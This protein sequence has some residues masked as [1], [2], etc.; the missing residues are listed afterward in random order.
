VLLLAAPTANAEGPAVGGVRHLVLVTASDSPVDGLSSED[1]RDAY[2]AFPIK[3]GDLQI[4]PLLNASDPVVYEV[5]LQK[6]L[7]MSQRNY[8]RYVLSQVFRYGGTRPPPFEV[9]ATLCA[10]LHARPG[11]VTFMWLTDAEELEG[12]KVLRELWAGTVN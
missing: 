6:V 7:F 3:H 4:R 12:I 10:A 2:L 1:L 5:F 8:D 9:L 11:A